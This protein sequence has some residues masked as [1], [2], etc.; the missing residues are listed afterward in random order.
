MF[1]SR[2]IRGK[3]GGKKIERKNGRKEKNKGK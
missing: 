2:K 1:G 3:M